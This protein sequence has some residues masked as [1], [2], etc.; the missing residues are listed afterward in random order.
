MIAVSAPDAQAVAFAAS[1]VS[2]VFRLSEASY[3]PPD[4]KYIRKNER[5]LGAL[6]QSL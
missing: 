2:A 5:G 1:E 4:K 3:I 6:S